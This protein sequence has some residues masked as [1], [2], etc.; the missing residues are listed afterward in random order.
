LIL[1]GRIGL[2]P[3]V[4]A[5]NRLELAESDSSRLN[6]TRARSNQTRATTTAAAPHELAGAPVHGGRARDHRRLCLDETKPTAVASPAAVVC[7]TPTRSRKSRR[8]GGARRR[9][10]RVDGRRQLVEEVH[11]L[12]AVVWP[13]YG[14]P[15]CGD[16]GD[17]VCSGAAARARGGGA[18]AQA[19]AWRAAVDGR[20]AVRGCGGRRAAVRGC[21]GRRAAVRGRGGRR[22]C[23]VRARSDSNST[24]PD[25]Q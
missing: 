8:R 12:E 21:G 6:R 22:R 7:V 10:R 19:T 2:K 16:G 18:R 4:W 3:V 14:G 13:A 25:E 15:G 9:R 5:R 23:A 24:G 20:A 17:R 1:L 11:L